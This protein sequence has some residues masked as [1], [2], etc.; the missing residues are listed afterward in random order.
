MKRRDRK[1]EH[2]HET[3]VRARCVGPKGPSDPAWSG[4]RLKRK[5]HSNP[6]GLGEEVYTQNLYKEVIN[7]TRS[8]PSPSP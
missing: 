6:E 8:Y 5:A 1:P 4:Q 7:T 2:P 3:G